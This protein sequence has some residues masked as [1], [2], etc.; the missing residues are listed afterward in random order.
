MSNARQ[1][2]FHFPVDTSNILITKFASTIYLLS[3]AEARE[4]DVPFSYLTGGAF[5]KF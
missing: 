4:S 2:N 3:E 5:F 1:G